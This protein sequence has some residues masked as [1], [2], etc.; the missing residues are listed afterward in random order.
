[1]FPSPQNILRNRSRALIPHHSNHHRELEPRNVAAFIPTRHRTPACCL[2]AHPPATG[3]YR[4]RV[5]LTIGALCRQYQ[6]DQTEPSRD[7]L[8]FTKDSLPEAKR[9]AHILTHYRR[10]FE[11]YRREMK[12]FLHSTA[13]L[14]PKS[15]FLETK[16][17]DFL[18]PRLLV[19]E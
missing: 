11:F 9:Q 2:H 1:M 17:T 6:P 19:R 7:R 18:S 12:H 15:V 14:A 4:H 5:S 10:C 8:S 3:K 13:A 16:G